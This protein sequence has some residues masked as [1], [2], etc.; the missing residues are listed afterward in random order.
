[1]KQFSLVHSLIVKN[2]SISSYSVYSNSYNSANSL[3][4]EESGERK[5]KVERVMMLKQSYQKMILTKTKKKIRERE[6][7]RETERERE[8]KTTHK[9]VSKL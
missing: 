1:M 5:G 9:S 7:E 4:R 2:I 3:R 8:K 6:R